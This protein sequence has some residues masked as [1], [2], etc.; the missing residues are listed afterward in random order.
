MD[1]NLFEGLTE[2][3]KEKLKNCK[4]TEEIMEYAANEGIELNEAQM[5]AISGGCGLGPDCP[6]YVPEPPQLPYF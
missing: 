2:E 3:Q 4:T 1:Q 6:S 5:A